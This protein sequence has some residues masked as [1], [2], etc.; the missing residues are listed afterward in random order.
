MKIPDPN[1]SWA[2]V[3]LYRWQYGELP[4]QDD[5]CKRLDEPTALRAMADALEEGCKSKNRDAMPSPYNVV[6]VMRYAAKQLAR[7]TNKE[8][9]S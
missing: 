2:Q 6:S 5:T 8:E 4:P 7:A 1:D 3:E 9:N